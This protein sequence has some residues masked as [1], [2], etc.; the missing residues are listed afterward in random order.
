M[1]WKYVRKGRL[2]LRFQYGLLAFCLAVNILNVPMSAYAETKDAPSK[3]RQE[4]KTPASEANIVQSD[5]LQ[6]DEIT[7]MEKAIE[8]KS[9]FYEK[10]NPFFGKKT[11]KKV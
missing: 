2:K 8:A 3:I 5:D 4:N 1:C 9:K 11:T 6:P 10:I 7:A